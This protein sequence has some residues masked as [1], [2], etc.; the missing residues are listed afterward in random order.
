MDL[1]ITLVVCIVISGHVTMSSGE[2]SCGTKGD[3]VFL[4]DNSASVASSDFKLMLDF[5]KGIVKEFVLSKTQV[6]VGLETFDT[7]V[8]TEFKLDSYSNTQDVLDAVDKVSYVG[9]GGTNT[10]DALEHLRLKSFSKAFGHRPGVPKLAIVVTDGVSSYK[11]RTTEQAR[12]AQNS[13]ITIMTV[14]VGKSTDL[15]ELQDIASDPDS[16]Y[17]FHIDTFVGL[18]MIKST[19]AAATC[20]KLKGLASDCSKKGAADIV[21]V[22]DSSGSVGEDNFEK[23][24]NF[25]MDIVDEFTVGPDA[26]QFGIVIFSTPVTGAFSLNK[27][28][29]AKELKEAISEIEFEDGETHTGKALEFLRQKS[30]STKEGARTSQK[31]PKI[32][33]VITD[34]HS[35]H[36]EKTLEEATKLK[37]QGVEIFTIGVGDEVDEDE[38]T[39]MASNKN[40]FRVDTFSALNHLQPLLLR[41][42][43]TAPSTCL[44][45]SDVVFLLD[46]SCS[47]GKNNFQKLKH[48]VSDVTYNLDINKNGVQMGVETYECKVHTNFELKRYHNKV[49]VQNA[50]NNIDYKPGGTNTGD[51]IKHMWMRSFSPEYGSR[52]NVRKLGIVITDGDSKSKATTFYQAHKARE[53]GVTMIAIGVGDMNVE[54]LKGIA[55]GTDYLLTTKNYDTLRDLTQSVTKMACEGSLKRDKGNAEYQYLVL[56]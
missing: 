4:L 21:F 14:G 37:V 28:D 25:T 46:S 10:G 50:I 49:Q 54:E 29:N 13:G 6:Q 47:V 55:N 43:C 39:K 38:L 22:L 52:D 30:F 56:N 42:V 20:T 51:A 9:G 34:G 3:V 16:K 2:S 11:N 41:Q 17:L 33:I 19:L 24:K 27:Y 12:L 31:V 36:K 53:S 18:K 7:G 35:T 5:V 32:A 26:V 44:G 1:R 8:R 40:I 15:Q 45:K 23:M 48:F